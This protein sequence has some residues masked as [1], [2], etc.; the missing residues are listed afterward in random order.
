[1]KEVVLQRIETEALPKLTSWVDTNKKVT[2]LTHRDF[3]NFFNTKISK[4]LKI[5]DELI[6][7]AKEEEFKVI[8][9]VFMY[10]AQNPD[11]KTTSDIIDSKDFD[12]LIEGVIKNA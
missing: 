9:K 8:G 1:M 3:R 7:P 2:K 5:R 10:I 12:K 4:E 6:S 11:T